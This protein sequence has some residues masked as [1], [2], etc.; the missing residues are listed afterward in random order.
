MM[1]M[2]A[3]EEDHVKRVINAVAP[4]IITNRQFTQA[5]GEVMKRPTIFLSAWIRSTSSVWTTESRDPAE[6]DES[7]AKESERAGI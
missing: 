3:L 2:F 5:L 1:F 4:D 6:G 7:V